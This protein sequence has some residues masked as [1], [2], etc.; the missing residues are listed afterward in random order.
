MARVEAGAR[1]EICN[2][3]EIGVRIQLLAVRAN[4]GAAP[5]NLSLPLGRK[6]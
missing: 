5:V 6:F 3:A 1:V 4:L 2:M